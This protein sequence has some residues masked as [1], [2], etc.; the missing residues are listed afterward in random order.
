MISTAGDAA[1][2][3]DPSPGHLAN[4]SFTLPAAAAGVEFSKADVWTAPVSNDPVTI[5]FKQHIG[6]NDAAAHRQLLQDADVHPVH[7]DALEVEHVDAAAVVAV[8][9]RASRRP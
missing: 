7:H 6:A 2:S 8:P 4:G 5:T 1:L 3:V 9:D